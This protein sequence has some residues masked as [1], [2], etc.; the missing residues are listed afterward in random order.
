MLERSD[1]LRQ[2]S[3]CDV[4]VGQ[5]SGHVSPAALDPAFVSL[6]VEG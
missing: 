1:S 2:Q 3:G 4:G 6:T 5:I